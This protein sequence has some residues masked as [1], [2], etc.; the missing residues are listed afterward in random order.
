VTTA[1][2]DARDACIEDIGGRGGG[3]LLTIAGAEEVG[4]ESPPALLVPEGLP[5]SLM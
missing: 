5:E 2:D 1:T 3:E 4:C